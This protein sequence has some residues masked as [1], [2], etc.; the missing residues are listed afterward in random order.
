MALDQ[1]KLSHIAT[2]VEI[3]TF[4]GSGL[5]GQICYLK[6]SK[7]ALVKISGTHW[8]VE[9]FSVE[10]VTARVPAAAEQTQK[11]SLLLYK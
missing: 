6:P 2:M 4:Q 7:Q 1:V 3:L 10:T 11:T 5:L 8:E 9:D